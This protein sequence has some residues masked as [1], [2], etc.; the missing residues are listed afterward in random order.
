MSL[1]DPMS[2]CHAKWLV[3]S[4]LHDRSKTWDTSMKLVNMKA[5]SHGIV[6]RLS[7]AWFDS[8]YKSQ[9]RHTSLMHEDARGKAHYVKLVLPTSF[10][11]DNH[12]VDFKRGCYV[13]YLPR[14][15]SAYMFDELC[16]MSDDGIELFFPKKS[17]DKMHCNDEKEVFI[18][19]YEGSVY[20]GMPLWKGQDHL[21]GI[22]FFA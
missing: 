3:M 15:W 2:L 16:R 7:C 13:Y 22:H 9:V 5:T 20:I 21:H 14:E 8:R 18:N 10:M 1:N 11:F 12:S 4:K 6:C 19:A 17:L